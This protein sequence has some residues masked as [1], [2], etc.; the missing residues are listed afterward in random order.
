M[1]KRDKEQSA[2]EVEWVEMSAR[3]KDSS[4]PVMTYGLQTV[5][6]KMLKVDVAELKIV[7]FSRVYQKDNSKPSRFGLELPLKPNNQLCHP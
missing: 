4:E 3:V 2:N 5:A 6:L 7:K 1:H